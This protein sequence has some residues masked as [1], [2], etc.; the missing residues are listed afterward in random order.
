M[1]FANLG[2]EGFPQQVSEGKPVGLIRCC[3]LLTWVVVGYFIFIVKVF[4]VLIL[5]RIL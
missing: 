2:N 1:V 5:L 3:V 4:N